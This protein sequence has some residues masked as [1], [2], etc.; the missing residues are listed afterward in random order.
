MLRS[1]FSAVSGLDAFQTDLDVVGNNIANVDTVGYKSA[2]AIFGDLFYQTLQ[3]ASAPT[4][5]QGGTNPV[6]VG[7][8]T[9]VSDVYTDTSQGSLQQTD[10][11]TDMAIQGNGYFVVNTGNG[12]SYTRAGQFSFDANGD[13]VDPNG[14][15]VLGWMAKNGV[16]PAT[17]AANLTPITIPI[18]TNQPATATT[19]AS[20]GGNLDAGTATGGTYSVGITAIDSLG[21][22]QPITVTFTNTATDAW[23][24]TATW[25]G[26]TVGSGS[27]SFS[28]SG[29]VS[30]GGTGTISFT[31]PGAAAMTISLNLSNITQ[32]AGANSVAVDQINGAAAGSLENISVDTSGQITGVFT[33]GLKEVLGQVALAT[34]ANPSGLTA[35][36]NGLYQQ[37]NN[38]GT[39]DITPA[40][41]GNAGT[42]A[43]GALEMSNVDLSQQFTQMM[44]AE[45]AFQANAQVITTDD[46]VLQS[47][48]QMTQ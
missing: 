13:L 32:F 28:T 22:Q 44:I 17:D 39:P 31:P 14:H 43:P 36:G 7:L 29:A 5:T 10:V 46:T 12:Q 45:R 41:T 18:T 15:E 16:L 19:S 4:A 26:T 11:Q 3:G 48:V 40:G 20:L 38:S 42:I 6:Q 30:S 23:S 37:S 35:M 2:S 21:N 27:L 9:T 34:F 1:L 24:W 25:N 33:N 47:L 8:G